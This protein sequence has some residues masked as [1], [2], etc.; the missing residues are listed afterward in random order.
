MYVGLG[1][2]IQDGLPSV[3]RATICQEGYPDSQAKRA[4]G[5]LILSGPCLPLAPART[6]IHLPGS[7]NGQMLEKEARPVPPCATLAGPPVILNK[8]CFFWRLPCL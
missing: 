4:S 5:L 3:R 2:E 6:A 8:S 7:L 1:G